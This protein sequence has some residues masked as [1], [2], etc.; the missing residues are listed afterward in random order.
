MKGNDDNDEGLIQRGSDKLRHNN[1]N[2]I[3]NIVLYITLS[4]GAVNSDF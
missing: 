3:N 4:S 1:N 2:S